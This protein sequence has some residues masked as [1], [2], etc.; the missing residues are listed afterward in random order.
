MLLPSRRSA[1]LSRRDVLA[2]PGFLM[3]CR[4]ILSGSSAPRQSDGT[5]ITQQACVLR[6]SRT[7]RR[8]YFRMNGYLFDGL[9]LFERCRCRCVP[10]ALRK[11]LR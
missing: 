1:P 8:S 9:L 10:D 6:G 4:S 11:D 3:P 2:V 7:D 5:R